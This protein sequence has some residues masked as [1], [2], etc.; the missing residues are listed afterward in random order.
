MVVELCPRQRPRTR[1]VG[2]LCRRQL[3]VTHSVVELCPRR[4][5]RTRSVA[6][7]CQPQLLP[8]HLVAELRRQ[9]QRLLRRQ[10]S[11]LVHRVRGLCCVSRAVCVTLLT[12]GVYVRVCVMFRCRWQGPRKV[13]GKA[14]IQEEVIQVKQRLLAVCCASTT[15][16]SNNLLPQTALCAFHVHSHRNLAYTALAQHRS[17]I[18]QLTHTAG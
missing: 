8:T 15:R 18:A 12:T 2:V 13:E 7:L 6:E 3:L 9:Q 17:D 5:P 10:A 11:R 14:E 16:S 1:S 4:L